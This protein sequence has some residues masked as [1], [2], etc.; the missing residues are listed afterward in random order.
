MFMLVDDVE[1]YPEFLPWCNDACVNKRSGQAVE[2]TLEL[3]K[4]GISKHFTTRNSTRPHE[5]IDISLLG[6]PFRHLQGGWTF[7]DLGAD[8]CKVT[9]KLD[10]EFDNRLV[11]MMFGPFFE[12]TCNSLVDAFTRRAVDV[13]GAR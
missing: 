6:G 2:A 12:E 10:F 8:G 5:A 1:A 11:D 3:H 7:R 13:F 9:L 4:G